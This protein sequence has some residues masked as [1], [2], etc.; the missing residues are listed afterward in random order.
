MNCTFLETFPLSKPCLF[1]RCTNNTCICDDGFSSFQEIFDFDGIYCSNYIYLNVTMNIINLSLSF[2]ILSII[3]NRLLCTYN[4][5]MPTT[6]TKTTRNTTRNTAVPTSVKQR[7]KNS[8]TQM[9][10]NLLVFSVLDMIGQSLQIISLNIE[11]S[12]YLRKPMIL[13]LA[14]KWSSFGYMMTLLGYKYFEITWTSEKMRNINNCIPVEL[15]RIKNGLR[16]IFL[17]LYPIPFST[18]I[19]GGFIN[20]SIQQLKL[21]VT[22]AIVLGTGCFEIVVFTFIIVNMSKLTAI[23]EKNCIKDNELITR[24][25]KAKKI[26]LLIMACT[27]PSIFMWLFPVTLNFSTQ[28]LNFYSLCGLGFCL[29]VVKFILIK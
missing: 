2:T 9:Y 6:I 17:L 28:V 24:N 22:I 19:I 21:I 10:L 12:K 3:L 14:L 5:I 7:K 25:Q 29:V 13:F 16:M 8:F 11:L 26:F 23:L 27:V 18:F 1:G 15:R 4:T 20:V